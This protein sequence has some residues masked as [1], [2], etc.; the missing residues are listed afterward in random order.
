MKW[1]RGRY[2]G[3]RIVGVEIKIK[4]DVT[5]WGHWCLPNRWGKCLGLGPLWVWFS[6]AYRR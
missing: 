5:T 2:N 1:P 4:I 3:D 6:A